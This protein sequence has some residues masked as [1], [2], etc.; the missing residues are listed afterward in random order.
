MESEHGAARWVVGERD[1]AAENRLSRELGIPTVVAAVLLGRGVASAEDARDFLNPSL[2]RLH[3]AHLL[4]DYEAARDAL[5][6]AK[7][8]GETIFVHGDYDVDGITSA[9]L[10]TRFLRSIE[11]KVVPH[12]PHR[13]KEGYGIHESAVDAALEAGAKLFLTC[14]CGISAH[15][16]VRQANAAGMTVIVTDHHEVGDEIPRA[17]AV[18]NPHRRDSSYPFTELS[19]AGVAFKFCDGLTADLGHPRSGYRRAFLDLA[20]LGTI[21]DVMPLVGE[22]RI[23]AKFGLERLRE[24]KKIGLQALMQVS[25]VSDGGS[26]PLRAYHVGFVLGPRLNAA[27]RIDDAAL[28]LDLLLESDPQRAHRIATEIEELNARRKEEQ[29]RILEE[30]VAQVKAEGS[31]KR[32]VIVVSNERW[33]SGIIGIV[34]G[35]LVEMFRRPVFVAAVDPKTGTARGSARTIPAFHLADAIHAHPALMSGG[36]HAMA[37]GFAADASRLGEMADVLHDYAGTFLAPEDFLPEFRVDLEIDPAEATLATLEALAK[38]EPFGFG[39]P[40]PVFLAH[41]VHFSQVLPTKNPSVMRL[42]IQAEDGRPAQGVLFRNGERLATWNTGTKV[43]VVFQPKID[44]FR[45]E[46]KVKWEIKDWASA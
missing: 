46:R 31:D 42:V 34:A 39:N 13:M 41:N 3:D 20:A 27:G 30:A 7:E 19:G 25:G 8:R 22:N 43:D 10:F 24:T 37:A 2:D 26:R 1:A 4:P 14:D 29:E 21:A 40:E 16:Q 35:R 12:V 28:A 36:G 38:L 11:C 45:G 18:V 5:F 17:A 6:G 32:N 44:E 9:A 33:H 15:E 23:I